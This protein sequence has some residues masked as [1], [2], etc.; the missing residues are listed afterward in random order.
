MLNKIKGKFNTEEKKSLLSNFFSLTALQMVNYI[1]PLIVIP[2]LFST[3]GAEKFGLIIFAQAIVMYFGLFINYGFNLSGTRE[4]SIHRENTKKISEIYSSIT[5]IKLLF[6]FIAFI[7]FI[8]MVFSFDKFSGDWKLYLFTFGTL[9][10]SIL[11]PVWFFQGMERMKYIT[12]I[13]T[14]SKIVV[15][16]SIFIVI[17]SA[18]DY[19]IVPVLYFIGSLLSGILS[20]YILRKL[21]NVQLHISSFNQIA[22]QLK[23]GWHL[24]I[25]NIAINMYRSANI[26]ILGFLTNNLYVGY[27][28]LAEKV[29]KA[30]QALMGPISETLYP[31]IAKKSSKQ[32][33]KS[34]LVDIF[35]IAKYYFVILAFISSLVILLAPFGVK[36]LSGSYINNVILD[37]R[38][39][40]LV[41]LFGGLNY[42]FG[43]IGL[44]NLGYKKYFMKSVLIAGSVNVILCSI[45]SLYLQDIGAAIAL[46]SSEL[47]LFLILTNKLYRLKNVEEQNIC[48]N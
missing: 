20:V 8:L 5:I 1:L 28:A 9:V 47:I 3:L 26:L 10:E 17:K 43:I 40:S 11:F 32:N 39:L 41:V 30:L 19:F 7:V 27:Y 2:Y 21:F 4:I 44:I 46:S 24:F 6:L 29:I 45:L 34:S 15:T 12:I 23:N 37:M 48:K 31:Y 18:D 14:I 16:I 38:I 13:Y 22:D 35:K 42:L 36:I 33:L 25:S